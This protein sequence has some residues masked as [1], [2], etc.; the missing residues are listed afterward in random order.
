MNSIIPEQSNF[1]YIKS[2]GNASSRESLSLLVCWQQNLQVRH[3]YCNSSVREMTLVQTYPTADLTN[4][5]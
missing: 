1:L 4:Y 2:E 5:L 3:H